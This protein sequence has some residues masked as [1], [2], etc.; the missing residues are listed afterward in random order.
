MPLLKI[1]WPSM[2]GFVFVLLPCL[3]GL[4]VFLNAS[5]KLS[6][7]L[8]LCG[9]F[10]NKEARL[11]QLCSSGWLTSS[12][13]ISGALYQ[14]LQENFISFYSEFGYACVKSVQHFREWCHLKSSN[15]WTS[16]LIVIYL[17][18]HEFLLS[19][20]HSFHI[21]IVAL[22]LLNLFLFFILL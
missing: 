20:P 16:N 19:V 18:L 22:L 10:R 11:P 12:I 6:Q 14:F 9:E 13:C 17:F 8:Q 4:Y 1:S 5:T 15:L 2:C 21:V 3:L 7:L